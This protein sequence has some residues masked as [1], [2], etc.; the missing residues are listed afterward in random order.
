MD[1]LVRTHEHRKTVRLL[2]TKRRKLDTTVRVW[3]DI[4]DE[5]DPATELAE[6][7]VRLLVA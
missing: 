4:E 2:V 6:S 5:V 1:R 3:L 7:G